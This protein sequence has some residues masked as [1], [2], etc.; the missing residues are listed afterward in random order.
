M[1]QAQSSQRRLALGLAISLA[2]LA[3]TA[4]GKETHT[5]ITQRAKIG[6]SRETSP[7]EKLL[8]MAHSALE[9]REL[10]T[11]S[12]NYRAVLQIDPNQTD[13][14]LHLAAI[15]WHQGQRSEATHLRRRALIAAPD[16][17][18]AQA[19]NLSLSLA[20]TSA[21]EIESRLKGL[22]V[23]AP[24]S[25]ELNFT[26]GTLFA[27]QQRWAEAQHAFFNAVAVAGDNPDYL[28]NLAVSLDH[29]HQTASAAQHYRLALIAARQRPASFPPEHAE[30]RLQEIAP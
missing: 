12:K 15:C 17:M 16:N 29:L 18:A 30:Q 26:L 24:D 23:S 11:A 7:L 2:L 22:L 21:S 4:K 25:G 10:E 20:G 3:T 28:F 6:I 13:A 19:A 14:L 5:G 27:R 8:A 1:R 9:K